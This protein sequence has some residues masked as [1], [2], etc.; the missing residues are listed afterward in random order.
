MPPRSSTVDLSLPQETDEGASPQGGTERETMGI[1]RAMASNPTKLQFATGFAE[2]VSSSWESFHRT[3]HAPEHRCVSFATI[4][5]S[6]NCGDV[7]SISSNRL[8]QR[9]VFGAAPAHAAS[10]DGQNLR[11]PVRWDWTKSRHPEEV[12]QKVLAS[13]CFFE[14]PVGYLVSS[15]DSQASTVMSNAPLDQFDPGY[16]Q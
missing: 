8:Q 5:S 13:Q 16:R 1:L 10:T 14:L 15:L 11:S 9:S 3:I 7:R 6:Q 12:Q 4:S 2:D